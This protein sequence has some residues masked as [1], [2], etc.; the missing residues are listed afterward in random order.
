VIEL[1]GMTSPKVMK[2]ILMLEEIEL[3]YQFDWVSVWR[4]D[5]F[6]PD[7][8]RL[9]PNSKVPVM[10]DADGPDGTPYTVFE[11]DAI[12]IYLAEKAGL[13]L[14]R[15]GTARHG[16]LQWLIVGP[17]FDRYV[18]FTRFSPDP[19]HEYPRSWYRTETL[20][21][22]EVVDKR[23]RDRPYLGRCGILDRR[24]RDVP[25]GESACIHGSRRFAVSRAVSLDEHHLGASGRPTHAREG[26]RAAAAV[27]GGDK[28]GKP[29]GDGPRVR[30][31]KICANR[32]E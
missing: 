29:G 9:N 2:I 11:S 20:R 31:R 5:Q 7:F 17:I 22:L 12:L 19:A 25:L 27:D 8:L 21:L 26:R 3:P 13:L 6:A 28:R 4:C 18:H 10:V 32:P 14:P 30:S 1:Y 24:R 15:E 23:L 16:C